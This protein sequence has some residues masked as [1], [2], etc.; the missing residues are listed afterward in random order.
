MSLQKPV[1]QNKQAFQKILKNYHPSQEALDTLRSTQ[2]VFLIGPSASGRNTVIGELLKTNHYHYVLSNTTR[3]PRMIGDRLEYNGEAYWHITE[4]EFLDGLQ[5][6]RY[7]E[8]AVIHEQQVSGT[9]IDEYTKAKSQGKAA[10]TDIEGIYGPPVFHGYSPIAQFIFIL[11]PVF[12]AWI[13]RLKGRGAISDEELCERLV[14]AKQEI[15]AALSRDYYAYIIS[16]ELGVNVHA[17][18]QYVR[19]DAEMEV[20]QD[21]A[22]KHAEQLLKS[23]DIF[24]ASA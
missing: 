22:K 9:V 6:G 20:D 11:P 5:N 2:V 10:I 16:G 15:E 8:A 24:L 18:D 3:P 13:N 21:E 19:G 14:S 23:I 17:I 4:D 12:D 1:L 7:L